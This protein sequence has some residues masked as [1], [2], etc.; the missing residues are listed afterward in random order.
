MCLQSFVE[1]SL[2]PMLTELVAYLGPVAEQIAIS[3]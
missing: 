1:H 2:R 3:L